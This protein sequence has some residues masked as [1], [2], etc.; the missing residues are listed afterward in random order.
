MPQSV[1]KFFRSV[2]D[3]LAAPVLAF[4]IVLIMILLASC[5][6]TDALLLEPARDA[7]GTP[8]W[9]NEGGETLTET[10]VRALPEPE[11][12]LWEPLYQGPKD[13]G[14]GDLVLW[15]VPVGGLLAAAST[16]YWLYWKRRRKH[17]LASA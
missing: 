8:L 6:M 17:A 9:I 1:R 4:F 12:S 16:A 3:V 15:G 7:Q 11:Q 5:Q 10:E 14:T 13:H 2:Y